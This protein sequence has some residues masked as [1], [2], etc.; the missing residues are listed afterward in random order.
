[1]L[2][3]ELDTRLSAAL[4]ALAARFRGPLTVVG[5][6]ASALLPA[7][8]TGFRSAL[9]IVREI[10]A[11]FMAAFPPGFSGELAIP[12]KTALFIGNTLSAFTSDFPLL[13]RIHRR[14]STVRCPGALFSHRDSPQ[15]TTDPHLT[16]P[17]RR[18]S[19]KNPILLMTKPQERNDLASLK[20]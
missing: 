12:R 4:S 16:A 7:F 14:E 2:S 13:R 10:S 6:I 3:Y 18:G 19:E 11:T 17:V 15:S 5:E 8:P 20:S 1:L 9:G